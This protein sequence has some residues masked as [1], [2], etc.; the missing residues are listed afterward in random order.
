MTESTYTD[1]IAQLQK[2]YGEQRPVWLAAFRSSI[3]NV[4]DDLLIEAYHLCVRRQPP[5]QFPTVDR[6]A[7]YLDEARRYV[8][9]KDNP[10]PLTK[11][12]L[13]DI[14]NT[15]RGRAGL[16]LMMRVYSEGYT[17]DV[18]AELKATWPRDPK[19]GKQYDWDAAK[20]EV[21]EIKSG[22]AM[23]EAAGGDPGRTA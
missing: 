20:R 16:Q 19:T 15:E 2:L 9:A 23:S 1:F 3:A 21:E 6:F 18:M 13:G 5:N 8:K 10:K 11:P 4:E 7:G 22:I 14:R 17:D 12:R